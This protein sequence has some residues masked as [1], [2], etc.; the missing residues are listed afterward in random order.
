[1]TSILT[2][3]KI[4]NFTFIVLTIIVPLFDLGM[5][6]GKVKSGKSLE[7]YVQNCVGNL[8]VVLATCRAFFARG[9]LSYLFVLCVVRNFRMWA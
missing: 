9:N 6:F 2:Y 7:V 8:E 4:D 1:L 3:D 5:S